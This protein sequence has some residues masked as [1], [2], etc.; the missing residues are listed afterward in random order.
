MNRYL[1]IIPQAGLAAL[2][3]ACAAVWSQSASPDGSTSPGSSSSG[4]QSSPSARSTP[5][6]PPSLARADRRFLEDEAAH[7]L[8]EQQVAQ[9]AATR[10]SDPAV[11]DF[12]S[13]LVED[14]T[15]AHNELTQLASRLG[16]ELPTEPSR[17][18]RRDVEKMSKKSGAEFDREFVRT[19]GVKDHQKEV[20][21][22]QSASKDLKNSELKA[23][24]DKTLPHM[25][26]HLAAAEKLPQAGTSSASSR[27]SGSSSMG[28]GG[29]SGSGSSGSGTSGSG[30][31]GKS[32]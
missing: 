12:A 24:V 5:S 23:W 10:S 32:Y 13:K 9:L 27:S 16:V 20:K 15:A 3:L 21:R 28:S 31:S 4:S 19:V 29:S 2:A 1:R 26:Q 8:Y 22:L 14:H 25:Q 17:A 18:M 11:K 6:N 30:N 7:S